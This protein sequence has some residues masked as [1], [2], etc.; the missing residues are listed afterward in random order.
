MSERSND[1]VAFDLNH[2]PQEVMAGL[3]ALAESELSDLSDTRKAAYALGLHTI[4]INAQPMLFRRG[5]LDADVKARLE[6]F[7]RDEAMQNRHLE[8][9]QHI[10]ESPAF[11]QLYQLA[12]TIFS[13]PQQSAPDDVDLALYAG[14]FLSTHDKDLLAGL[15]L[16][17]AE[18]LSQLDLTFDDVRYPELLFRYRARNFPQSLSQSEWKR[19]QKVRRDKLMGVSSAQT[20]ASRVQ[21]EL[22]EISQRSDL[23][24][25][26]IEL[27]QQFAHWLDHQ[28]PV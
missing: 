11:K 21:D 14:R 12:V 24:P 28:P 5:T 4:R 17:D 13:E 10:Q 8:I 23:E 9:W 3:I 18:A 26:Q 15:P 20:A 1:Y 22:M 7:G 6:A 19:W 2:D 27:L 16:M 25:H